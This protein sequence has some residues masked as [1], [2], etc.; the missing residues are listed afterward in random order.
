MT[1]T[2]ED[3]DEYVERFRA[4]REWFETHGSQRQKEI[5][6]AIAPVL[7]NLVVE[8]KVRMLQEEKTV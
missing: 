6:Y 8:L 4:V 5:F 3:I 1:V 2:Q 7:N